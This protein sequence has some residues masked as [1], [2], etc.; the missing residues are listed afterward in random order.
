MAA[1]G[2]I[3]CAGAEVADIEAGA[4]RPLRPCAAHRHIAYA[5]DLAAD[6]ARAARYHAAR[7]DQQ[8]AGAGI[9]YRQGIGAEI[10]GRA[11][12]ARHG[13]GRAAVDNL[14]MSGGDAQRDQRCAGKLAQQA[15]FN[16]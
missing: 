6:K 8:R 2:D 7:A 11:L 15:D 16:W 12:R 5:A 4:C 1:I 10:P 3:Q 9:A 14:R 13:N